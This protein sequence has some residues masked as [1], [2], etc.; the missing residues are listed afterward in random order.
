MEQLSIYEHVIAAL[1]DR[2]VAAPVIGEELLGGHDVSAGS[3]TFTG[4]VP[5]LLHWCWVNES[6]VVDQGLRDAR[7]WAGFERLSRVRGVAA[8]YRR[9]VE[10]A[11]S[12]R[13]V[14]QP[15]ARVKVPGARIVPVE[16]GPL[17]REWFLVIHAGGYKGLLAARDL[18]GFDTA[19]PVQ[20]RSFEGVVTY[21]PAVVTET[22]ELLE[23]R[24]EARPDGV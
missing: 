16:R 13:I 14:G 19:R 8:R 6:I 5:Y 18:D 21:A 1:K 22:L 23:E 24:L 2:G 20:A 12:V 11:A 9:L 4:R 7:V 10:V 17:L 3:A 15:D